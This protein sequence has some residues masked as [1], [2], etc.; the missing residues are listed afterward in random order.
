MNSNTYQNTK[1]LIATA[2]LKATHPRIA[3]LHELLT[4]EEHPTAEQVHTALQPNNPSVSLGSVYRILEKLVEVGLARPVASRNGLKRY[5]A[6]TDSHS[7]IY[8]VNTEEIQ[9][10]YDEELNDLIKG[11]FDKKKISNFKITEVKLQIN[12]EKADP[13]KK[14]TIV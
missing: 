4:N 9:D 13:D 11:Y 1:E 2:G 7:H 12:G 6:R 8:A 10:Y 3:V 14:V 5:D